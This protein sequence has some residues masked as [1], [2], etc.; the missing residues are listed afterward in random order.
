[1]SNPE[2]YRKV[3]DTWFALVLNC[4][5]SCKIVEYP[6]K[7]LFG[8]EVD[9]KKKLVTIYDKKQAVARFH[10]LYNMATNIDDEE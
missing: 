7:S 10:T 1:M 3:F 9:W 4:D 8:I 6:K 2:W 5:E